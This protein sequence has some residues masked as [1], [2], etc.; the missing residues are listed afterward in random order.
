MNDTLRKHLRFFFAVALGWCLVACD[1]HA[2]SIGVNFI[3]GPHG[4]GV[5]GRDGSIVTGVAG[6]VPQSGWNNLAPWSEDR[7]AP[8]LPPQDP[9][10]DG[11]AVDLLDDSGAVTTTDISWF[12]DN[13][14]FADNDANLTNEDTRLMD[15]YLDIGGDAARRKLQ[16][17][18]TNIPYERYDLYVYVGSDGDNRL[19]GVSLNTGPQT[20]FVSSTGR[21]AFL[22]PA[23]Y[24]QA[25]ATTQETA[26]PS[27][28]LFYPSLDVS[29]AAIE[30]EG[31][32]SNAGIHAIQVVD[33]SDLFLL[34]IDSQTGEV[35]IVGKGQ[36]ASL[37]AAYQIASPAGSLR[38]ADLR[39]LS[40]QRL[41]EVDGPEDADD[42][43]GNSAGERWEV[44]E[45]STT[46]VT[47]ARLF[48]S[49]AIDETVILS[50]GKIYDPAV[51][52]DSSLSFSYALTTGPPLNGIVRFIDSPLPGDYDR[53]GN[54]DLDDY[55]VWRASYG[56]S[57]PSLPADGARSGRIDAA[58]YTVWR[59]AYA[60]ASSA[61]STPEPSSM[62][63][64]LAAA[65]ATTA[66][67]GRKKR[68]E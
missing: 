39:S 5:N 19:A 48:G 47:E 60:S 9:D 33:R 13:T 68:N 65:A 61:V 38:P 57:G 56:A 52:V 4:G 67:R 31:I 42:I 49:T 35:W 64:C 40:S 44:F 27:N 7:S 24:K 32:V 16:V 37:M 22:G 50:L 51:G 62:A 17:T 63:A 14:Y 53:D 30:L 2:K 21:G 66:F 36:D 20:F 26:F 6:V 54:V 59:D 25:T 3:G 15:G 12:S 43:A 11:S 29:T 1:A 18:L 46:A 10:V 45:A 58:D 41:D 28:Y 8:G 23:D 34:E 55:Q